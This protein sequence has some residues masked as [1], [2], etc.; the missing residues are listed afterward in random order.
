MVSHTVPAGHA[1]VYGPGAAPNVPLS[2][3]PSVAGV[4]VGVGDPR[5]MAAHGM[6]TPVHSS[7][8]LQGYGP[9]VP[10]H[11]TGVCTFSPFFFV[12]LV[13]ACWCSIFH[14]VSVRY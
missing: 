7:G 5:L 10:M 14:G 1:V 13:S 3:A 12:V 4:G 2:M 6:V 11:M 9:G 8:Q